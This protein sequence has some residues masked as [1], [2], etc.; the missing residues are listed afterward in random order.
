MGSSQEVEIMKKALGSEGIIN[1]NINSSHSKYNVSSRLGLK[2]NTS[3][4]SNILVFG[5]NNGTGSILCSKKYTEQHVNKL[6]KKI[7]KSMY[8]R[9]YGK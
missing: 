5:E 8:V 1:L 9:S 7:Q 6:Y 2:G 4:T 3:L